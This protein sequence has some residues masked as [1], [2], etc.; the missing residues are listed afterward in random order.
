MIFAIEIVMTN[1]T[2]L[3][4]H[5]KFPLFLV[6][7]NSRGNWIVKDQNGLRGGLFVDRAQAIRYARAEIGDQPHAFVI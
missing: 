1:D 6:G 2:E 7:R 4:S 5:L 3:P